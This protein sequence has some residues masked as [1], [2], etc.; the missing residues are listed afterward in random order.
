MYVHFSSHSSALCSSAIQGDSLLS[1]F[2]YPDSR[3]ELLNDLG[4]A[5]LLPELNIGLGTGWEASRVDF[6][7]YT[8]ELG[9]EKF[10][11]Y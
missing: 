10:K 7:S 3:A 6:W 11:G 9:Q 2:V 4:L 1:S 5:G 8:G